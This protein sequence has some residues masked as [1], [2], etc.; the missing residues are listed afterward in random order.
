MYKNPNTV[1]ANEEI[2]C[3]NP[4]CKNSID[5]KKLKNYKAQNIL[6]AE[7]F[8]KN[9][10]FCVMHCCEKI[11]NTWPTRCSIKNCVAFFGGPYQ[12]YEQGGFAIDDT[13]N[14]D[15]EAHRFRNYFICPNP[16]K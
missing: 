13:K 11:K 7:Y 16:H 9:E 8:F 14:F 15:P 2:N 10:W 6:L 1:S 12:N 4:L 3:S 5:I